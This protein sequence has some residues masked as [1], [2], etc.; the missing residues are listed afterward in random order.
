MSMRMT[1][2]HDTT[3]S[4]C[5]PLLYFVTRSPAPSLVQESLS[6]PQQ[7][8]NTARGR[9]FGRRRTIPAPRGPGHISPPCRV[10]GALAPTVL[11]RLGSAREVTSTRRGH[12]M[13]PKSS[14]APRPAPFLQP[15][16]K[17]A[18]VWQS[19]CRNPSA[20]LGGH[21]AGGPPSPR[22]ADLVWTWPRPAT[23]SAPSSTTLLSLVP[24]LGFG[25]LPSVHCLAKDH[26][27]RHSHGTAWVT[28]VPTLAPPAPRA[29]PG[30]LPT[31]QPGRG[32]TR[33]AHW[34]R[35]PSG[36]ARVLPLLPRTHLNLVGHDFAGW[37]SH[38]PGFPQGSCCS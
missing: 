34:H 7:L 1:S 8:A 19:T 30:E 14:T 18:A 28:S 37:R 33:N 36:G 24:A 17:S 31:P 5:F 4:L 29:N 26:H 16:P 6:S 21:R 11:T 35:A 23:S 2:Q 27:H 9:S 13:S 38:G 25:H 10:R 12:R 15:M 3:F 20:E 22:E 32:E